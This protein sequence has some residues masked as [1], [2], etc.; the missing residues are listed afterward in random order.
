V[1]ILKGSVYKDISFSVNKEYVV[2]IQ[3]S[4][5]LVNFTKDEQIKID[6][7]IRSLNYESL[8]EIIDEVYRFIGGNF[9][10]PWNFM[11]VPYINKGSQKFNIIK[12]EK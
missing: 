7:Y 5:S 9:K 1:K 12:L 6:L 8:F 2:S 3:E 4:V 10:N 11:I